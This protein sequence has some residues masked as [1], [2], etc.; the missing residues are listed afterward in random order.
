MQRRSSGAMNA[1]LL[2][3]GNFNPTTNKAYLNVH[4]T[5]FPGG[6]SRGFGTP[7]RS[8]RPMPSCWLVSD[9]LQSS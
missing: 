1:L 3:L 8:Q 6:E 5:T 9:C 2:G 4:T 7:F